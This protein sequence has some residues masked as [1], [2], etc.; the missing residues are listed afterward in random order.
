M[1]AAAARRPFVRWVFIAAIVILIIY[2]HINIPGEEDQP[3][4]DPKKAS[5]TVPKT[6][7][8]H[9]EHPDTK[10]EAPWNQADT[11]PTA[12]KLPAGEVLDG[13]TED[14]FDMN[15][16]KVAN[17]DPIPGDT[18]GSSSSP[19]RP[20]D[21]PPTQSEGQISHADDYLQGFK[22]ILEEQPMSIRD[23]KKTCQWASIEDVDFQFADDKDWVV[24]DRSDE[25]IAEKQAQWHDYVK[26][27]MMPYSDVQDK[28]EGKGI[29]ICAGNERSLLRLHV[30][31]KMLIHVGSKLPVEVHY[32]GDG[33]LS[34]QNRTDLEAIFPN[35]FF[36]DLNGP[37]VLLNTTHDGFW[38]NYNVKLASLLNSRFAEPMLLDSDNV[39]VADPMR[40][41]ESETYQN[42]GT[43]FYPDIA[44]TR[45]QNP[46]WAITNTPCRPDEYEMESGQLAVDK[47]RFWY[48]LQ[49]AAFFGH[50]DYYQEFLLGDKDCFRFAWHALKT[51]YGRP[52]RWLTS[53]G[54]VARP[55]DKTPFPHE[56]IGISE[57]ETSEEV[58]QGGPDSVYC[59]HSFGQHHPDG[60]DAPILFL[61]G[62]L[63]KTLNKEQIVH[64]R[65][66][67]KGFFAAYKSSIKA[68][69]V[70]LAQCFA[71]S[72]EVLIESC[73]QISNIV[74]KVRIKWDAGTYAGEKLDHVS[75]C[76]DM[77]E[78][79]PLPV[80][81]SHTRELLG[82]E[83]SFTQAG[84][85][86]MLNDTLWNS[87]NVP[88]F[89]GSS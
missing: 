37:D 49:L 20:E 22:R 11:L 54:Y 82:F 4:W 69:V 10:G 83:E 72:D 63:V 85:F 30:L 77:E 29:V 80:G 52:A 78:V 7:V 26:K 89:G 45:P 15:F 31:L 50:H 25:E 3:I 60:V 28:F 58:Y 87:G 84:G 44:R 1:L 27:G 17:P 33:E 53:V 19:A 71:S 18:G 66:H 65:E 55:K 57:T 41:F 61:H 38:I 51:P 23:T 86:W 75:Q 47:R 6:P 39:P 46:M 35:L 43:V 79:K 59:G 56:D 40:L 36:N 12:P 16:G 14:K 34:P 24:N 88:N 68:G 48:H 67:G 32:Y 64:A 9:V 42:F 8:E 73:L 2:W 62:G 5:T 70:S 21:P 81:D 13:K 76:T 74:E